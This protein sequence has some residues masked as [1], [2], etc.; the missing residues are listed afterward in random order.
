MTGGAGQDGF[1]ISP[2]DGADRITDFS[3]GS[4]VIDLRDFGFGSLANVSISNV[5]GGSLI[6]L[7]GGNSVM[8]NNMSVHQW[9]ASDFL[10]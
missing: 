5:T 9:A 6:D 10:L 7:G 8:V 4:D 2:G 3:H 1:W